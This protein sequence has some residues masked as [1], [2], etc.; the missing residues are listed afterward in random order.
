MIIIIDE[1]I[2]FIFQKIFLY[3][4]I[5][6][7]MS[8]ALSQLVAYGSQDIY[9]TADPEITFFKVVYR[10]YTNFAIE[11]I[12]V[13][14]LPAAIRTYDFLCSTDV[15]TWKFPVGVITSIVCPTFNS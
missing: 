3:Y 6:K 9:L 4:Y 5:I 12:G 13:I 14:P 11:T 1:L 15:F 2:L 8:G 10:R 7:K